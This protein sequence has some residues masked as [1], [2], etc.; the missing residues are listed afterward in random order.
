MND[1][2]VVLFVTNGDGTVDCSWCGTTF[3][4]DLATPDAD[5]EPVC[6]ECARAENLGDYQPDF[7]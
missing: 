7:L 5:D 2:E 3:N 4:A 6:P 1:E